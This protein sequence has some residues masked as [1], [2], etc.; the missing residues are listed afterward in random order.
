MRMGSRGTSGETIRPERGKYSR[1]WE[2]IWTY[3]HAYGSK[4]NAHMQAQKE[5]LVE[6]VVLEKDICSDER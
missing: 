6:T 4:A 5:F 2:S 3:T 1:T